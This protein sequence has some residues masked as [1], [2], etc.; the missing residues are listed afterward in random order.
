MKRSK[1]IDI[2]SKR[3]KP[4]TSASKHVDISENDSEDTE[5]PCNY[6]TYFRY[7]TKNNDKVGVC[8]LCQKENNVIK[9]IKMKNSNTT[10]LKKHLQKCHKK[11]F[12][13]LFGPKAINGTFIL[14]E[15][16]KT[17]DVFLNVSIEY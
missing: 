14:P 16:Q 13:N 6:K 17:V 5:V 11:A 12:E 9:E 1:S 4:S 7:E 8:L 2:Q 3:I 15:K 10:G